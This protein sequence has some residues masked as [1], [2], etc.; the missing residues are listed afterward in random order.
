MNAVLHS[1]V[2]LF[3]IDQHISDS[4]LLL[5]CFWRISQLRGE[6]LNEA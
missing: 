4:F 2:P 6:A 1:C 3:L 5:G